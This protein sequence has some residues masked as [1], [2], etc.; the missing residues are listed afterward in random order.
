MSR[1]S[2]DSA[3]DG[4]LPLH[5]RDRLQ[6]VVFDAN[7]Y[8]VARPDLDHLRRLAARLDT[9][10]IETW[11]PEPVAWEW[12]EHIAS[13][14]QIVKNAAK[15]E[16]DRLKKAGL[17]VDVPT[18]HYR[19]REEVIEAFLAGLRAIPHVRIT[20]LTGPS[21]IEA[22]KDQILVRTPAKRKGKDLI[23]TGASDSAW[24]RDVLALAEPEQVL[25]VSSDGDVKQAFTAWDRPVPH[26]RSREK[27]RSSLFDIAVDDGHAQAAVVSYLLKR[28]PAD[29]FGDED[30]GLDIGGIAGLESA[31]TR[32]SDGDGSSLSVYGASVT[33][34]VALAGLSDVAVERGV[35]DENPSQQDPSGRPDRTPRDDLGPVKQDIAYATVFFLAQGEATVQTLLHGGDPDVSVIEYGNVLVRAQLSFRFTDGVITAMEAEGEATALLLEHCFDDDDDALYALQEALESVP[36]LDFPEGLEAADPRGTIHGIP[37]HVTVDTGRDGVDWSARVALWRGAEPD[38]REV[39]AEA[40]VTCTYDSSSWWGGSRDGFQ[41]PNGHQVEV[42]ADGLSDDHGVWAVPAWLIERIDW[43]AFD[44]DRQP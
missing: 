29:T 2:P 34:L 40:E 27:L 17:T 38:T 5:V 18:T 39:A 36:G 37:A 44:P 14:W 7:A 25:I 41:G 43:S 12:A 28:L 1:P 8:G 20:E 30:D 15:T 26:I 23:K 21:A 19:S 24:L 42:S 35:P 3:A 6:A 33:R 11:V 4:Q 9:I 10:G 32:Q 16:R 31:I 22:L 13:D